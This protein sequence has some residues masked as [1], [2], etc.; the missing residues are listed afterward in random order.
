MTRI[1]NDVGISVKMV[2]DFFNKGW[3]KKHT[4]KILSRAVEIIKTEV[5]EE[6]LIKELDDLKLTSKFCVIPISKK[7]KKNN[8]GNLDNV[9]GDVYDSDDIFD[10]ERDDLENVVYG[11]D[12]DVDPDDYDDDDDGDYLLACDICSEA[13]IEYDDDDD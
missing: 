12:L 5:L 7:M 10:M 6:D 4:N 1:A 9:V 3:H 11:F 13:G 2:S 8:P